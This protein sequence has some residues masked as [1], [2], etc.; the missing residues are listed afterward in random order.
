MNERIQFFRKTL[1]ERVAKGLCV[2]GE[3]ETE[4][5]AT[6][7]PPVPLT[8]A[9]LLFSFCWGAQ[10]GSWGLKPSA[11]SWFSLP[12]TATGTSTATDSNSLKL[13]VAPGYI[14]VWCPP[15]SFGCCICTE[16]NLSTCQ[17]DIF[18][19]MHL[20]LDWR[21]GR[22]SICY[23]SFLFIVISASNSVLEN[24]KILNKWFIKLVFF[25]HIFFSSLSDLLFLYFQPIPS[26]LHTLYLIP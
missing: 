26:S 12:W 19:R 8:I 6:Y 4:Q 3:L 18:G 24:I 10:L 16:F 14:I 2:R 23:N 11:G 25:H 13:S 9:A 15:A 21:L 22:R 20:F 7:W 1:F 5:I 17:G